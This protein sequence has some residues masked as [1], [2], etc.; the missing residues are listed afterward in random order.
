MAEGDHLD[1][2]VWIGRAD[3]L[4][5]DLVVLPVAA[6]LRA[7]VAERRRGVPDLPRDVGS[8]LDERPGDRRRA[9]GT[10]GHP[11][12][13]LVL[14]V[15]H[16]LGDD[17]GALADPLEHADVL[18]HRRLDQPVAVPAGELGEGGEQRLPAGRLGRQEVLRAL[19]RTEVGS[20]SHRARVPAVRW[21]DE[22][23]SCVD[24]RPSREARLR[25][26][27]MAK[28]SGTKDDPWQ[29][30]TAPGSSEYTMYRDD[31]ADPPLLVCQVGSTKL[32]YLATAIDDLHAWLQEQGDWVDLG[33]ADENKPAKDGTVEAFGRADDN[34]SAAGTGSARATAAASG[35][36]CRRCSR[37]SAR[38]SSPTR[39]ATTG[40]G[41]RL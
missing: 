2:D 23:G 18:E 9:L 41:E 26:A 6:G 4:D 31:E 25:W 8:V 22:L 19:R 36:T 28:G 30:T 24:E 7:L 1:V 27:A 37:R 35:C 15:V 32:T 39:P 40:C 38:P 3:A 10:Q 13:A 11:A 21:T 12:A 14:E 16:L 33:A 29:L 5:A 34:P 17:V 20:L